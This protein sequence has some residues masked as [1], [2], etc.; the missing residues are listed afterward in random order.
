M[1]TREEITGNRNQNLKF[2]E[3]I[4]LNLPEASAGFFVT[5]IDYVLW[6]EKHKQ[7]IILEIKTAMNK[8]PLW[9]KRI[10]K[11]IAKW[12]KEGAEKDGW[13][14]KGYHEIQFERTFFSDGK[15]FIDDKE[16]TVHEVID[17]LKLG[18]ESSEIN[19]CALDNDLSK[20]LQD[21]KHINF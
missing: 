17:F 12:I 8:S 14:F 2:S 13:L 16:A 3:W 18:F 15:V 21:T 4:R 1:S 9:Q 6:D 5:D 19:L 10:Y 11:N 20:W 7:F